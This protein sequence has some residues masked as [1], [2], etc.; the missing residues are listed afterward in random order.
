MLT[1]ELTREWKECGY[2][3][4]PPLLSL[5]VRPPDPAAFSRS[6]WNGKGSKKRQDKEGIRGHRNC[7]NLVAR[8]RDW[9]VKPK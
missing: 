3:L 7:L 1:E 4:G 2:V 9:V 8:E 6:Y 5:G